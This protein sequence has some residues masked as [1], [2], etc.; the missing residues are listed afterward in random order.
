MTYMGNVEG[1][2]FGFDSYVQIRTCVTYRRRSQPLAPFSDESR[3]A[4]HVVGM[5]LP[6]AALVVGA[7]SV[8]FPLQR[9]R[10]PKVL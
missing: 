7:R 1:S 6:V 9:I 2:P 3:V 4:L 10:I 8:L 5:L